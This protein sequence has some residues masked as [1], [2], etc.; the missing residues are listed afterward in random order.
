M[1]LGVRASGGSGAGRGV[2]PGEHFADAAEG[3]HGQGDRMSWMSASA[4]ST[5]KAVSIA[6][7]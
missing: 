7:E 5:A 4:D 6:P 1:G 2:L 3:G